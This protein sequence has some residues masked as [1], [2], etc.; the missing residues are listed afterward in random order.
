M[1]KDGLGLGE[2]TTRKPHI[3]RTLIRA[4]FRAS[5][6]MQAKTEAEAELPDRRWINP[7]SWTR[8]WR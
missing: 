8:T 7:Q 3:V 6:A 5:V 1:S 2:L 4:L